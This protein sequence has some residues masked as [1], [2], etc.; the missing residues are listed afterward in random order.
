VEDYQCTYRQYLW[1]FTED[2]FN[3]E[4][5]VKVIDAME[6]SLNQAT[7]G[8]LRAARNRLDVR[9]WGD[10]GIPLRSYVARKNKVVKAQ[11]DGNTS[12]AYVPRPNPPFA[13]RW[14]IRAP[15][16]YGNLALMAK[17]IRFKCDADG[18]F[19]LSPR[20][21]RD[22]AAALYYD[23]VDEN[24][25]ESIHLK[26]AAAGLETLVAD[27]EAS[28]RGFWGIG[29][30][31]A[32]S[33]GFIWARAIFLDADTDLDGHVSLDETIEYVSKKFCLCD[34]DQDGLLSEREV[35]EA[36]DMAV[37][38]PE[39]FRDGEGAMRRRR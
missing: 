21:I 28:A 22:G 26:T 13:F 36:L 10:V 5:M 37:A 39:I 14:G 25:P 29:A 35:I 23:L 8:A 12:T 20:E 27:K 24:K 3:P 38:P 31:D 34:Q 7:A 18:D 30:K 2:F 1:R 4:H 19:R 15:Q 32:G 16:E 6:G 33:A 9:G 11:L 17:A